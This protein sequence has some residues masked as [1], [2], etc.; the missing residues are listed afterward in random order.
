ML[1]K[2]CLPI[3]G[4]GA[5]CRFALLA[6]VSAL[7]LGSASFI[8][9]RNS[10]D[11]AQHRIEA[12]ENHFVRMQK[13]ALSQDLRHVIYDMSYL[14]D[15][16][17]LHFSRYDGPERAS[18]SRHFFAEDFLSFIQSSELYDHIRF[19]DV[20]GKE[21]IKVA[22]HDGKAAITPDKE[23]QSQANLDAFRKANQ[24]DIHEIFISPMQTDADQVQ[25]K[26]PGR[27]AGQSH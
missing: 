16:V 12:A 18:R 14:M 23:L 3:T 22:Y 6:L 9:Y 10:V 11:D 1:E 20:N 19:M 27:A 15:Q 25:L 2:K 17:H 26:K 24:L 5:G 7:L 13:V 4:M 8:Y 21:L